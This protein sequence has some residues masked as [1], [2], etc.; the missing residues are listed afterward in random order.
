MQ[1]TGFDPWIGKVP[2]WREWLPTPVFWPGEF[3]GLYSPWGCK[4]SDTTKRLSLFHLLGVLSSVKNSKVFCVSLDLEPEPCPRASVLFLGCSSQALHPLP[5]LI[6]CCAV[7][8]SCP[9]LCNPMDCSTPGSSVLYSL[10]ELAQLHVHWVGDCITR[11]R[12]IS[13]W[14]CP[15]ELREGHGG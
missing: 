3:H 14:I 10:P 5:P 4:E 15:L 11:P 7:P 9:T 6:C 1:E 12:L 13:V 2:W 8:E